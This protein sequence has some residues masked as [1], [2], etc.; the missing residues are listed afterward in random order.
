MWHWSAHLH[1]SVRI[2]CLTSYLWQECNYLLFLCL[3]LSI[4]K[5]KYECFFNIV[6]EINA[7]RK[8]V[9]TSELLL[10][11][12]LLDKLLHHQKFSDE[13]AEICFPCFQ[14]LRP[15]PFQSLVSSCYC[16][17]CGHTGPASFSPLPSYH[18]TCWTWNIPE[19]EVNVIK[20][21]RK[22]KPSAR[23]ANFLV[24]INK[25]PNEWLCFVI[26]KSA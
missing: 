3:S 16:A 26:I 7:S 15:L 19:T 17:I 12:Y 4:S 14:Q 9:I 25:F 22:D 24:K 23:K 10:F 6:F 5:A 2:L 11:F 1:I 20:M 18:L 21:C 13:S 8:T